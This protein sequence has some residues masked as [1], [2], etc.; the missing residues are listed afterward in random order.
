MDVQSTGISSSVI[1]DV[2]VLNT[3][4][5]ASIVHVVG[6]HNMAEFSVGAKDGTYPN[7]KVGKD[8]V[9][10]DAM[11]ITW[12]DRVRTLRDIVTNGKYPCVVK[13]KSGDVGKYRPEGTTVSDTCTEPVEEEILHVLEMRRHKMVVSVKLQWD[14]RTGEYVRTEK[15]TDIHVTQKGTYGFYI[16]ELNAI[17]ELMQNKVCYS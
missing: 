11:E 16:L 2:T 7:P 15:S 1:S 10:P 6:G 12:E 13:I 17:Y 3:Y 4:L 8:G 9:A 14:R 5:N